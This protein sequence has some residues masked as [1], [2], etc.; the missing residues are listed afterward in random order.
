MKF[1]LIANYI[2]LIWSSL[3][4]IIL[5]PL[6][7]DYLGIE[8]YG[9]I[10]F[11]SLLML[12]LG[13]MDFGMGST[14]NR[15]MAR[16]SAGNKP[17]STIKNLLRTVEILTLSI[18]I[19]FVTVFWLLSSWISSNW[20]R[21]ESIT[22]QTA[23]D[24]IVIMVM[25]SAMRFYEGIYRNALMGLQKQVSA[26][27]VNVALS[28]LRA[29]G[30]IF[31]FENVSI[32]IMSFFI[33]QLVV[34]FIGIF[35]YRY[36]TYEALVFDKKQAHF[37]MVSVREVWSFAGGMFGI[38]FVT[39]ALTTSD[40]ILLSKLL[41]LSDYG[42]YTF[43]VTASTMVI[44]LVT[45]VINAVYPRLCQLIETDDKKTLI[46]CY[47]LYSQLISS[48]IGGVGINL[49]VFSEQII[50]F[51]TGN[52]KFATENH[53][54]LSVLVLANTIN[55][56]MY[57]PYHLQLAHGWTQLS[58][59]TNLY[60]LFAVIPLTLLLVPTYGAIG[61]AFIYLFLNIMYI[62]IVVYIMHKKIF[63]NEIYKWYL[64]DLIP[65]ILISIL[66]TV[67]TSF[68]IKEVSNE[69]LIFTLIFISFAVSILLSII[70]SI[71][72]NIK[73][74]LKRIGIF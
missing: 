3:I 73:Y 40:K 46:S 1:N 56:M 2:G 67:I 6:Y 57:L 12:W 25:V 74:Y 30:V 68:I 32:S 54:L 18:G 66:V 72:I 19:F 59:K 38:A 55:A 34:T 51:W 71:D 33:W 10:G 43:A 70:V 4:G 64:L 63:K 27:V 45:P 49:A 22:S 15:E 21:L 26:N 24:V 36:V 16:Y 60:S 42:R 69:I 61:A 13:L 58:F 20:I 29:V 53:F 14:I 41:T 17:N 44:M 23:S 65:Q 48:L 28:T 62:T 39:L 9:L 8:A 50:K 31:I 52:P 47:H 37:S 35:I 7:I 5:I 11:F